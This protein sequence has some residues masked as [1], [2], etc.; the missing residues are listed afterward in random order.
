MTTVDET[1][2]SPLLPGFS[3]AV[4]SSW[5]ADAEPAPRGAQKSEPERGWRSNSLRD[6][7]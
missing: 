2:T 6:Q 3:V 4:T 5:M 1:L 7:V